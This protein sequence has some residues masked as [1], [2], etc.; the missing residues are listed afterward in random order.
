MMVMQTPVILYTTWLLQL[1]NHMP[2]MITHGLVNTID[3]QSRWECWMLK[4]NLLLLRRPYC[5]I[6]WRRPQKSWLPKL[7]KKGVQQ[8]HVLHSFLLSLSTLETLIL[9]NPSSLTLMKEKWNW[10]SMVSV[11]GLKGKGKS[12][13]LHKQAITQVW[14]ALLCKQ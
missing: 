1:Y 11:N 8:K 6:V 10:S 9:P 13:L 2:I 5:R 7:K 12:M 3:E 14:E 4:T